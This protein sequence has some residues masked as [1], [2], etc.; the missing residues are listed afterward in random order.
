LNHNTNVDKQGVIVVEFVV[1]GWIVLRLGGRSGCLL[2]KK[3]HKKAGEMG[4]RRV[5]RQVINKKNNWRLYQHNYSISNFIGHSVSKN[6]MPP[7]DL[8][9][10]NPIII[11]FV[12]PLVY[13]KFFFSSI[14][15]RT[16]FTIGLISSVMLSVKVICYCIVW[17]FSHSLFSHCNS[18]GIYQENFS[19]G[20]YWWIQG[21]KK[22]SARKKPNMNNARKKKQK[23]K[24]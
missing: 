2:Q 21:W 24:H 7:Y 14:Y 11:P 12:I 5:N 4:K 18:L 1:G 20:V 3:I 9:M 17:L 10:L 16:Y 13:T 23:W 22:K 6:I 8:P 15:L 19:I